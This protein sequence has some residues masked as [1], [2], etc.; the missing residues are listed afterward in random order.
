MIYD[1]WHD[2]ITIAKHS[3]K[4]AKHAEKNRGSAIRKS[5]YDPN[6]VTDSGS[7]GLEDARFLA[8]IIEKHKPRAIAEIGTWF[9]TSA[10]AMAFA[11]RCCGI[12][13]HIYTCD[14]KDLFLEG[15]CT[16]D[17]QVIRG[18][19]FFHGHSTAMLKKLWR[20]GVV[21]DFLFVDGRLDNK[22]WKLI[23]KLFGSN[24]L[25]VATHDIGERKGIMAKR[26]F[27][28]A[29]RGPYDI[30]VPTPESSIWCAREKR[31][32]KWG[33]E[34]IEETE[35]VFFKPGNYKV[36]AGGDSELQLHYNGMFS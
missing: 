3:R 14:T 11:Q 35:K 16:R 24:P 23:L 20:R 26:G 33:F 34:N 29:A 31:A 2:C 36:G 22:D 30:M 5:K 7:I 21:L 28:R 12:L 1:V 9:G 4:F 6:C 10:Y 15:L 18:V 13:G 17:G 32:H 25:F 19:E 27:M 8:D